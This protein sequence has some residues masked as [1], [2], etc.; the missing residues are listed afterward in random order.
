MLY[1]SVFVYVRACKYV[2]VYTAMYG[3]IYL[4]QDQLVKAMS[5]NHRS[6]GRPRCKSLGGYRSCEDRRPSQPLSAEVC[7]CFTSMS[8]AQ[9]FIY[10]FTTTCSCFLYCT[11]ALPR[12]KTTSKVQSAARQV[13]ICSVYLTWAQYV[14]VLQ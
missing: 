4:V 13:L 3:F 12:Q 1:A 11:A 2:C 14:K 5:P 6:A 10:V 8:I 9:L 7:H